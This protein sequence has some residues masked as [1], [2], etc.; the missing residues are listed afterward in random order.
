MKKLLPILFA[1]TLM[2]SLP[3]VHA[4]EYE[5]TNKQ[6]K[7]IK[8]KFVS[9][10]NEAVTISKEGKIF[11]V[12]LADLSEK[13]QSLA[14]SLA[15]SSSPQSPEVKSKDIA[16]PQESAVL[17]ELA[18]VYANKFEF[19]KALEYFEKDLAIVLKALGPKHPEVAMSYMHLGLIYR[20]KGEYDKAISYHKKALAMRLKAVVVEPFGVATSY[21]NLGA[22]YRGKGEKVI[23]IGYYTKALVISRRIH[24]PNHKLTKIMQSRI[25]DLKKK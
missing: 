22:A 16:L 21:N 11:I 25:D 3:L 10:T 24:G 2:T 15:T 18:L 6:G 20:A 9:V 23:A 1:A 5:W 13:S 12:R 4:V 17:R 19:D 7:T 8:A 14:R